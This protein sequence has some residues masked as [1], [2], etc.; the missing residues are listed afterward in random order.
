MSNFSNF[1]NLF[2]I[3]NETIYLCGNSLGPPLK[4]MG[5]AV[6]KFLEDEWGQELVKG[7]NSKGWF[8][9]AKSIGKI[10]KTMSNF[11]NFKNLFSIPN[12]LPHK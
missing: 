5:N 6:N 8:S 3:P 1:K 2:S 11:S 7:W 12:E 10:E 9:Q 4:S